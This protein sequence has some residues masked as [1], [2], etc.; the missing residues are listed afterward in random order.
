MPTADYPNDSAH[1][2][3][4]ASNDGAKICA[5][6]TVS[7]YVAIVSRPG[8]TVDRIVP[9]GDQPYWA[10]TSVDGQYCF[11]SNS[12]SNSVS[13]ISYATATEVARVPVGRYPQRL[14]AAVIP[15]DVLPG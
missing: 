5:A 4:A 14:H 10:T 12:L 15:T 3:L 6:A 11:V 9:V 2:G 13:V 7:D 8:L 1:H